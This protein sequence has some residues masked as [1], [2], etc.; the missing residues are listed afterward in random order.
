MLLCSDYRKILLFSLH[1]L[2]PLADSFEIKHMD[3]LQ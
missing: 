3:T 1:H 2:D